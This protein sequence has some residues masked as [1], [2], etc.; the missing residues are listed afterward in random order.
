MHVDTGRLLRER[1]LPPPVQGQDAKA[2]ADRK[3]DP[4]RRPPR[5]QSNAP[6]RAFVE[7]A[8]RSTVVKLPV[9]LNPPQ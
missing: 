8:I 9:H 5:A 6:L 1:L 3:G 2:E 4:G 7:A